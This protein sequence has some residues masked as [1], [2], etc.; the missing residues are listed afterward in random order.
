M[1]PRILIADDHPD[2]LRALQAILEHNS[3][4]EVCF[5]AM[6]GSEALIKAQELRPD[7]IILD[8]TMPVMNGIDAAREISK[9][10][11]GTPILLHTLAQVPQAQVA[12]VGIREVISKAKTHLLLNAIQNA[13][14]KETPTPGI[15][16]DPALPPPIQGLETNVPPPQP[17]DDPSTPKTENRE[18]RTENC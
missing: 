17:F 10:L 16:G 7:L 9:V 13:L 12:S 3:R 4:F 1:A 2:A 8:L 15:H 18:L 11:P 14:I 5:A 6:N